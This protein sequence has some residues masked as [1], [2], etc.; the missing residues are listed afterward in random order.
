[1]DIQ[2]AVRQVMYAARSHICKLY[3]CIYTLLKLH[4]QLGVKVCRFVVIFYV[5]PANQHAI[6]VWP[7]VVQRLEAH[8]LPDNIKVKICSLPY[9]RLSTSHCMCLYTKPT[10]TKLNSR[11]A[12]SRICKGSDSV[13]FVEFCLTSGI[14]KAPLSEA[15]TNFRT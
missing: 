10:R 9:Q 2:P 3:I 1:M 13:P 7:F 12:K 5:R 6:T 14:L 4:S 15:S 11:P 8:A